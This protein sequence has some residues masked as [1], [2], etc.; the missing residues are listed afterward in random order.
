MFNI[1]RR[2][3]YDLIFGNVPAIPYTRRGK[4]ELFDDGLTMGTFVLGKQ[5]SGKTTFLANH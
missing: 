3:I 2:L 4:G 5:G 1:D